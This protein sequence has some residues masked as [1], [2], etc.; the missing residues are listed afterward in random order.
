MIDAIFAQARLADTHGDL[1]RNI[2]S[3]RVS[4]DLFDD[5]SDNPA[6][7]QTAIRLELATKPRMFVSPVPTID[8]PFEEARWNDAIHY[9]FRH[10][11]KSR[12]ADGSFGVWYGSD[13]VETSVYETLYHWRQGLLADA[14]HAAHIHYAGEDCVVQIFDAVDTSSGDVTVITQTLADTFAAGIAAHPADW[15]MLQPQ[16]LADL[17]EQ[18]RARLAGP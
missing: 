4:Q 14:P 7:W 16:W 15:H 12:Y 9:P 1:V 10:W 13:T 17:P 18:R 3:I 11:M 6:D 2:V 8:R 5:L